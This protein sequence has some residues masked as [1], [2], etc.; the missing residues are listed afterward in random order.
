MNDP[1]LLRDAIEAFMATRDAG[2]QLHDCVR[3]VLD[4]ADGRLDTVSGP[5]MEIV[6]FVEPNPGEEGP[7][8]SLRDAR[9]GTWN[10]ETVALT[11]DIFVAGHPSGNGFIA[12]HGRGLH[13][14]FRHSD[15]ECRLEVID[16]TADVGM[17]VTGA[18]N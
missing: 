8:I 2:C 5:G 11:S 15:C 1:N 4:V 10:L 17:P 13:Q 18:V 7:E 6:S 14:W 12:V 16:I 3:A 9:N